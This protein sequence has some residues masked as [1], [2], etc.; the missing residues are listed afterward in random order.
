MSFKRALL[1]LGL[2]FSTVTSSFAG[3]GLETTRV[4]Y[5]EQ[6]NNEGFVAFNTDKDTNY[7]LQSWIEDLNGKVTQSFVITPPLLKLVAQQKNT[8]QVTK[9]TTLPNDV[10]SMYWIN[11]KFV[12]PS[13]E[14]L[15]NVL[16]YSMTNKIKLIYR[17][18]SLSNINVEEEVKALK[19]SVKNGNLVVVNNS[20]FFVNIGKIFINN[21]EIEENPGYLPPKSET[22]IKTNKTPNNQSKIQL[23]YIDD[24]GKG[25]PVD[26][27]L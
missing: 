13:N 3:F 23:L 2:I 17:P 25:V 11:V 16:R 15:E 26:F 14:N 4:I 10:E 24:F 22:V 7:L 21:S 20:P 18:Q 9:N 6:S 12:A 27:K 19:W 5:N 8:L 1:G